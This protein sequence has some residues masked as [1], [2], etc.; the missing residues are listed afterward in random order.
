[1]VNINSQESENHV[2]LAYGRKGKIKEK[3]WK[4]EYDTWDLWMTN[5]LESNQIPIS[6]S[7]E[8]ISKVLLW[9]TVF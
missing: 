3:F 1:M 6:R 5:I 9:M 2:T 4:Q 7:T 8:A